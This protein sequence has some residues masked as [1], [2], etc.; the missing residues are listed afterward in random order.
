MLGDLR[1]DADTSVGIPYLIDFASRERELPL[2]LE[3]LR[4]LGRTRDP[5]AL[6]FL[7]ER[8]ATAVPLV[9]VAA[10]EALSGS[11]ESQCRAALTAALSNPEPEVI[12]A[13]LQWFSSARSIPE[14]EVVACLHHPVWDVRRLAADV[15]GSQATETARHALSEH[16]SVESESIVREAVIRSLGRH[17][18][19]GSLRSILP[20]AERESE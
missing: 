19:T 13:A 17:G 15:L 8:V 20:P 16:L 18:P 12:K 9:S 6:A 10:V 4:A 11:D 2:T 3:T 14:P 1:D 7:L 5:R